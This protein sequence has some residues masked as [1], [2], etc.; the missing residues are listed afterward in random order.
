MPFQECFPLRS[1]KISL[2][3]LRVVNK[4]VAITERRSFAYERRNRVA[5]TE[6]ALEPVSHAMLVEYL[7]DKIMAPTRTQT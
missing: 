2:P 4:A 3:T 7:L 5:R 1:Q 6:T